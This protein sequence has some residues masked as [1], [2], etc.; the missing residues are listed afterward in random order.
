MLY[1]LN[2]ISLVVDLINDIRDDLLI[3]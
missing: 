2:G 3:Q 1:L